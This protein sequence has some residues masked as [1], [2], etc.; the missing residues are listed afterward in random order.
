MLALLLVFALVACNGST[1]TEE[2]DDN[3]TPVGPT[4]SNKYIKVENY[5]QSLWDATATVGS[6]NFKATDDVGL[7]LDLDIQ[8]NLDE[9]IIDLGVG[10]SLVLDRA[11]SA[12]DDTAGKFSAAKVKLYDKVSGDNWLTIY[13]FLNDP[14][15]IYLSFQDQDVVVA[16]D[17]GYNNTFAGA[18]N[19]FITGNKILGGKSIGEILGSILPV[20]GTTWSLDTILNAVLGLIELDLDK[21]GDK[22]PLTIE[23]ICGLIEGIEFLGID[24]GDGA[25]NSLLPVLKQ[26]GDVLFPDKADPKDKTKTSCTKVAIEG[27]EGGYRYEGTQ[28]ALLSTVGGLINMPA[29]TNGGLLGL[30]SAVTIAFN[31]KEADG[32]IVGMDGLQIIASGLTESGD[33]SLTIGINELKLTNLGNVTDATSKSQLLGSKATTDFDDEFNLN[34]TVTAAIAGNALVINPSAADQIDCDGFLKLT[35]DA[36]VDLKGTG[37]KAVASLDFGTAAGAINQNVAKASYGLMSDSEL[38]QLVLTVDDT[39]MVNGKSIVGMF[40]Q[41]VGPM[42]VNALAGAEKEVSYVD[43]NDNGKKDEGDTINK[44]ADATV[45]M[46]GVALANSL[47]ANPT[48]DPA[49][50]YATPAAVKDAYAAG[51]FVYNGNFTG[52]VMKNID[53]NALFCGLF[54]GTPEAEAPAGASADPLPEYATWQISLGGIVSALTKAISVEDTTATIKVTNLGTTIAGFFT[55]VNVNQM[56][57]GKAAVK[58]ASNAVTTSGIDGWFGNDGTANKADG[59]WSDFFAGSAWVKAETAE[60]PGDMLTIAQLFASNAEVSIG[61]GDNGFEIG[62]SVKNGTATIDLGVSLDVTEGLKDGGYAQITVPAELA[63][64]PNANGWCQLSFPVA[65]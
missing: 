9:N 15:N 27:V 47:F 11:A 31:T 56:L 45:Q 16:F 54:A 13:Y 18:V 6:D 65:A 32:K 53:L 52:V 8:L 21:D 44:E 38:G 48:A 64:G 51:S 60:K 57:F 61:F 43:V 37:T 59:W 46:A 10:L 22:E 25:K 35:L 29:L 1:T 41:Y 12:T 33:A 5:F 4:K 17:N 30:D 63:E 36:F 3:P 7:D 26:L 39:V 28:S 23:A 34:L 42:I 2:E 62:A 58:N 24:F 19:T 14:T 55:N 49:V 40:A 50:V 20:E